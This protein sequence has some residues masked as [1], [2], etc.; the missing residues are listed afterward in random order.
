MLQHT[1]KSN[2][3]ICTSQAFTEK[4]KLPSSKE[5]ERQHVCI[6]L[7]FPRS[8]ARGALALLFLLGATWIFGV[9][10]VVQGSVV[11]AYL[12]TVFNAFQGMFIFIFL[13]VLSRKVSVPILM[14]SHRGTQVCPGQCPALKRSPSV[15]GLLKQEET[16]VPFMGV[17]R[18]EGKYCCCLLG[19]QNISPVLTFAPIF[20]LLKK[21]KKKAHRRWKNELV[22]LISNQMKQCN[23]CSKAH[24]HSL[25]LVT[26]FTLPTVLGLCFFQC[27]VLQ[28][29]AAPP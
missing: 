7:H 8:C 18:E 24:F 2:P 10:H 19:R 21:K 16:L 12:F 9:L 3:C 14:E 22:K 13:C 6:C 15:D 28:S 17:G 20:F 23:G 5:R 27:P 11:T 26:G 4:D 1:L 29:R 25:Q